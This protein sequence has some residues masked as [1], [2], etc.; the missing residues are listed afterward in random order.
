MDIFDEIRS[1]ARKTQ[2]PYLKEAR[3]AGQKI[4]GYLCSYMPEEILHAA[5]FIPY[6]LR[7]V[8]SLGTEKGDLY[9]SA[10]NCSFVRHCFDKAVRGDFDFLDGVI[11]F[12]GCDHSRRMY[13]NWRDLY[14][15]RQAGPGFLHMLIA[16]HKISQTAL[17][18][19]TDELAKLVRALEESFGVK[20]TDQKLHNSICLYNEKRSLLAQIFAMRK[21]DQVPL[22]GAESIRLVLALNAVP[23]EK[24]VGLL[25]KMIDACQDRNVAKPG[26]LRLFMAGGCM[27]ETDHMQLIE[28]QGGIVVADNLCLGA[29]SVHTPIEEDLPPVPA[30]ARRYLT[31]LSCP[32][33][34]NDFSSRS[35]YFEEAIRDFSVDAVITDKL[36]FCDLWGG[37]AFLLKSEAKRLGIPILTLEREMHG[38]AAGQVQTRV[39]AF[40]EK[41]A[42]LTQDDA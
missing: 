27:E 32:R 16:P 8:E 40:F 4:M 26:D 21:G 41:I 33:M 7:T 28:D 29:R 20:I 34:V 35:Q 10:L 18:R 11:F 39:Q 37:E 5:G 1:I 13:D 22:T 3:S 2:N 38:G 6:R 31:H 15:E 19:Y 17:N 12:N 30:I 42:N 9:Y 36:M 14:R 24:A 23:V 25:E